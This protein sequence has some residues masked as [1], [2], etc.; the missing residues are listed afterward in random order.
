[1]ALANRYDAFLFDLDGVVYRAESRVEHAADSL[2]RL[3]RLGRPVAFMTN[4]SARTPRQ[5][6]DKLARVGV[7]AAPEDVVSS[8]IVTAEV[9]RE[10]G[11]SNAF[12]IGEDGV[13]DALADAGVN[14]LGPDAAAADVVVVGW[15]RGITYDK[16]RTAAL[17]V[18][19]G[20]ELVATNADASYPGPDGRWPGA[21][22]L[23]AAV[24]A[25]TGADPFVIGKPHAPMFDAARRRT[26]G[27][28][29]LVVG[30]RL[31]TDIEGARALG[32]DSLLVL[33]GI[34]TREELA[35]S[36]IRPTYVAEDLRALFEDPEPVPTPEEAGHRGPPAGAAERLSGTGRR[37]GAAGR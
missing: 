31:D 8:G 26:G 30:D 17:L 28:R 2:E 23:L 22:A 4:N 18:E 7:A 20:A 19:R 34:S 16:L 36:T 15:D 6:V 11:V 3:T 29:P 32:I 37:A 13:L 25:T 14:V 27:E 33:T 35:S 12:V 9:L 1:M 24:A 5:V 21:G 10:R